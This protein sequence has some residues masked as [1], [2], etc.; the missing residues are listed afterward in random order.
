MDSVQPTSAGSRRIADP[1]DYR[2]KY[3]EQLKLIGELENK[4]KRANEAM[5]DTQKAE[6]YAS[7]QQQALAL[8]G[9]SDVVKQLTARL[10]VLLPN[11]KD[12]GVKG[13]ALVAQIAVA[14]GLDP[15]PGSDHVY[16]YKNRGALVVEIGYKGLLHLA[17]Q[18]VRFTHQSRAMT[19]AERQ[20]HGLIEA[21]VGYITTLYDLVKARECQELGIPYYPIVGSAKWSTGDN[22]PKSRT[23]AWVAKKNSLKDALRQIA[24]T[25]TRMAGALDEYFAQMTKSMGA[26][27]EQTQDGWRVVLPEDDG[28]AAE[29]ELIE[30]G[31]VPPS[32]DGPDDTVIDA[33]FTKSGDDGPEPEPGDTQ[34][35]PDNVEGWL[36]RGSERNLTDEGADSAQPQNGANDD[37]AMPEAF[38]AAIEAQRAANVNQALAEPEA[39]ATTQSR[40]A[41]GS[42]T[43]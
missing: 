4:L 8:Y 24:T 42:P 3:H 10:D 25:G 27:V 41:G 18:Q 9:E 39:D 35:D 11:A 31:V 12:I 38:C 6:R 34:P 40:R 16:A 28:D 21:D 15:L 36:K 13:V 23:P 32:D 14:H 1:I 20:E 2:A 33:T 37:D 17:R 19:D 29:R 7:N 22:V 26:K 30:A 43:A 5:A